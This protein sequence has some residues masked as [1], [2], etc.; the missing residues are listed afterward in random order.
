MNTID[1]TN[2]ENAM[3]LEVE[4]EIRM[5]NKNITT[6]GTIKNPTLTAYM[7]SVFSK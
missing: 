6:T 7:E 3:R 5:E 2:A 1:V 4:L